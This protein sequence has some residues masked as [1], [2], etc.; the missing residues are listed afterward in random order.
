MENTIENKTKIEKSDNLLSKNVL[1]QS[2]NK[3]VEGSKNL[4][5]EEAESILKESEDQE[6]SEQTQPEQK[7]EEKS[8]E[9]TQLQPELSTKIDTKTEENLFKKEIEKEIV[10]ETPIQENHDKVTENLT[11][12]EST[13]SDD[14]DDGDDTETKENEIIETE[15]FSDKQKGL[16]E[17]EKIQVD[18]VWP[19]EGKILTIEK[20]YSQPVRKN[21]KVQISR[22]GSSKFIKKKFIVCFEESRN[23]KIDGEIGD[24][25]Y[26]EPVPS[27]FYGVDKDGKIGYP[28]IQKACSVEKLKNG[29]TSLVKKMRCL[30]YQAYPNTDLKQSD[31][32]YS[33]ALIG[34]KVLVKKSMGE[35][36][37]KQNAKLVIIK[38]VV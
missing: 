37:G 38:F 29:F 27:V 20:V 23:I 10:A 33:V 21:D 18:E 6:K 30:F 15:G 11:K 26:N 34:T 4:L 9:Q 5:S 25:K 16:K 32:D 22:D 7:S 14:D 2:E 31:L 1:E 12:I 17:Y 24:Y 35:Y 13:D 36:D 3:K 19:E 8:K 28:T